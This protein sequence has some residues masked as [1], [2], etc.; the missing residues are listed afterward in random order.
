MTLEKIKRNH[1]CSPDADTCGH[2]S[3]R[4]ARKII[5][6]ERSHVRS[7]IKEGSL[8]RRDRFIC[9]HCGT[10]IKLEDWLWLQ[11]GGLRCQKCSTDFMGVSFVAKTS[12][13]SPKGKRAFLYT[14]ILI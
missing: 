4:Q 1:Y 6:M 3:R 7:L 14:G 2:F 5:R 8:N 13:K 11:C 10:S 12:I 9:N